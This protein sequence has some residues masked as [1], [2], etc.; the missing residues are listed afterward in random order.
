MRQLAIAL[1]LLIQRVLDI[2][3]EWERK[4]EARR[5]AAEH[6]RLRNET[7]SWWQDNFGIDGA[8]DSRLPD[9]AAEARPDAAASAVDDHRG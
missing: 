8:D 5:V 3:D 6:E 1:V 4:Q 9:V 2:W 7:I